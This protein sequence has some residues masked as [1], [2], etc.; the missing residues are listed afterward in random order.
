[1]NKNYTN[2]TS[3]TQPYYPGWWPFKF[4]ESSNFDKYTNIDFKFVL[5]LKDVW[6][7]LM[8]KFLVCDN[9]TNL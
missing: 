2:S 5:R 1:M 3:V 4:D 6:I 8:H 7:G 9:L